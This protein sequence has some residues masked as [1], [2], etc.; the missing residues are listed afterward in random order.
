MK[1]QSDKVVDYHYGV[2]SSEATAS[3]AAYSGKAATTPYIGI[4][5]QF[6]ITK[7]VSMNAGAIYERRD[8]AIRNSSLTSNKKSDV[9]LNLGVT[10]WF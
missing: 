8:D 5:S 9:L 3:R 10:Y 7:H 4:E 6:N 2:R 1:Y